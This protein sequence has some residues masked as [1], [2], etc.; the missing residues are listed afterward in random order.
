MARSTVATGLG[1]GRPKIACTYPLCVFTTRLQS[2]A[3]IPFPPLHP[4]FSQTWQR[5]NKIKIWQ[6]IP[7]LAQQLRGGSHNTRCFVR[8][9][10]KPQRTYFVWYAR[11]Y[12]TCLRSRQIR[13]A[14]I[15]MYMSTINASSHLFV[16]ACFF[17]YSLANLARPSET[18]SLVWAVRSKSRVYWLFFSLM[19]KIVILGLGNGDTTNCKW[20]LTGV[21]HRG[22][23]WILRWCVLPLGDFLKVIIQWSGIRTENSS[24][25]DYSS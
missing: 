10:E 8:H 2:L 1:K 3:L 19:L 12:S 6:P 11:R 22:W 7:I 25:K 13:F 20:I 16:P 4:N 9:R 21:P 15:G 24:W 14:G 23:R 18:P 17:L 5:P